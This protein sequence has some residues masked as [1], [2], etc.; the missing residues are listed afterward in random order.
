MWNPVSWVAQILESNPP[1]L[2]WLAHIFPVHKFHIMLIKKIWQWDFLRRETKRGYLLIWICCTWTLA[3]GSWRMC[4]VSKTR[5]HHATP[6]PQTQTKWLLCKILLAAKECVWLKPSLFSE[7][8]CQVYHTPWPKSGWLGFSERKRNS[9]SSKTKLN[10]RLA[11]DR[12]PG[13]FIA[14]HAQSWSSVSPRLPSL[15]TPQ[16]TSLS[17]Q[18]G[19]L[20]VDEWPV[21]LSLLPW[22]TAQVPPQSISEGQAAR[23]H[24][25]RLAP[26]KEQL[27][28]C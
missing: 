15:S 10:V 23:E 20:T 2:N 21:R 17:V 22:K 6:T 25:L 11:V 26:C 19:L 14:R 18:R 9:Y 1:K 27:T 28:R 4:F 5:V 16:L 7:T 13:T 3:A 8:M 24:W 12:Q